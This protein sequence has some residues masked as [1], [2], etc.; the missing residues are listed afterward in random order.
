METIKIGDA[1]KIL[2]GYPFRSDNYVESGIRIIRIANVQK[3]FIE[4]SSPVF[5]PLH[6]E[7]IDKCMLEEGDLLISLTGNVGRV[8]TLEKSFLPAALNQRVACLRLKTDKILKKYLFH[9]LNSNF[10]EE[11]CILASK[12]VAQKNL[13]TEWLKEYEI[14]LYP[15]SKQEEIATILDCCRKIISNRENE[16]K[17]L[18]DL[19]KA[20]FVCNLIL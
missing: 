12:G 1:C 3:G 15:Q 10:F 14:P 7:G 4:D 6:S 9:I 11:Q 20:R 5:Y 19:I 16:L 13:S 18:D 8:A 17:Q 2:N